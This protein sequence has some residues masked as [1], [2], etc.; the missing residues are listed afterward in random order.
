MLTVEESAALFEVNL[1]LAEDFETAVATLC[2]HTADL[3]S[4]N[5][6]LLTEVAELSLN[7]VPMCEEAVTHVPPMA[8]RLE[9]LFRRIDDLAIVFD[10][11]HRKLKDLDDVLDSLEGNEVK[12]KALSVLKSLGLRKK[13]APTFWN[14][15]PSRIVIDGSAPKEFGMRM[16]AVLSDLN[17]K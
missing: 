7:A 14:R 5:E 10:D 12:E 17:A 9:Q 15:I 11:V 2:R 13:P 3:Q 1:N 4:R 16:R 6:Q 8:H